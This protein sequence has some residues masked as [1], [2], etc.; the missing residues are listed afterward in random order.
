MLQV[1]RVAWLTQV[2]GGG[3]AMLLVKQLASAAQQCV[4][5]GLTVEG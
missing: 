1:C 5:A 4:G 2:W 3:C